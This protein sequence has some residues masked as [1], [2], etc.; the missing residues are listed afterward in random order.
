MKLKKSL[1]MTKVHNF[2]SKFTTTGDH[3]IKTPQTES[4]AGVEFSRKK[5]FSLKSLKKG[6]LLEINFFKYDHKRKGGKHFRINK[7]VLMLNKYSRKKNN[8]TF[9]LTGL[10][11]NEIVT[12]RT[13]MSGPLV[14]TYSKVFEK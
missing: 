3:L 6:D 13:L 14:A 11:K 7:L 10:Y 2:I 1:N 12:V 4:I 9:N 5:R 8:L